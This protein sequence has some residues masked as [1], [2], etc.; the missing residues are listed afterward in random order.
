[1]NLDIAKPYLLFLGDERDRVY[2]K[3]AAGLAQWDGENCVGQLRLSADTVDVGLE[4]LTLD[5]A[6]IRGA[7]TVV[8]GIVVIGG[9]IPPAT[10]SVLREALDKG[11]DVAAGMH[12]RLSDISELREAAARSGARI[13]DVRVPPLSLPVGTGARRAGKRLLTMGTDCALGKKYTALALTRE[14]TARGLDVDFRATGQTGILLAGSGLPIDAVVADFLSGAAEMVSPIADPGHWDV[15]EGQGSL[16]HPGYAAVTMGL[17]TGSQPDAFVVCTDA[18]RTHMAGWPDFLLPTID[19]VIEL[20]ILIGK[21]ANP[22]IR[23][24]G[25]SVNTSSLPPHERSD[26]RLALA[27]QYGVPCG[28]PLDGG[29]GEIVSEVIDAF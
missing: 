7:K 14:M 22:A 3:T 17:L 16:F 27:A 23:C 18:T 4:D 15:I 1:M 8:L 24:V 26:Y 19:E 9:Q 20:T 5:E 10:M 29:L 13:I 6:R 11:L 2:A 21:R 28:D 12:D 25:I